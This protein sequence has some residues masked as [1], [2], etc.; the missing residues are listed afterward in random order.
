MEKS[1][2]SKTETGRCFFP[3]LCLTHSCNL[4]CVYCYQ[5]HTHNEKMTIEVA[6]QSIDWIFNNVPTDADSIEIGFIGGEPLLEFSL[7]KEIVNYVLKKDIEIPYIFFANTNGTVLTED[8]KKW[9][10]NNKDIFHLGLSIDGKKETHNYN[11]S[12]SFDKID[13]EY[14]KNNWPEQSVKMTISQ[15][16]IK[17]LADD[18]KYIHSIG[19]NEISGV[20]LAEG[21]SDWDKEEYLFIIANQLKLL[22]EYYVENNKIKPDLMFSKRIDICEMEKEK[23][24]TCGIGIGSPFFDIDGKIYPCSYFTPMTFSKIE[25][26]E[27]LKKDFTNDEN[28]IDNDCFDNCY[29]YPICGSCYGADYKMNKS[30]NFRNRTKCRLQKIICLFVA[31]M[32]AQRIVKDIKQFNDNN[33]LYYTINAIK[34]IKYLYYDEFKKYLL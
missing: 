16:S 17:T 8:M 28:F 34:K 15:Q 30:F 1:V 2:I 5:K 22:V 29:I 14:F 23:R 27:I 26:T 24:R 32:Y 20:N 9:F 19:F 3:V 21:I 25:L 11:R 12:N 31:D 4:N 13:I 7:I 18:I 33:V 6:R 10:S